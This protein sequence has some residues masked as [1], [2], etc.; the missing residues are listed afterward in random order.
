ME[1]EWAALIK[2]LKAGAVCQWHVI[3][4]ALPRALLNMILHQTITGWSKAGGSDPPHQL[5]PPPHNKHVAS[6]RYHDGEI[7]DFTI[8]QDDN[9]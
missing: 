5:G 3:V 6:D 2:N 7:R 9:R 1:C 8:D 4:S